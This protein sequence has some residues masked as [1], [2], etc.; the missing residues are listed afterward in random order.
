MFVI[1]TTHNNIGLPKRFYLDWSH[2]RILSTDSKVRT[3]LSIHC[4]SLE[5]TV[6]VKWR[7][8][9]EIKLL[10]IQNGGA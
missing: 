5:L 4:M 9:E 7:A 1:Q 6:G 8:R 10:R 3:T 2:H